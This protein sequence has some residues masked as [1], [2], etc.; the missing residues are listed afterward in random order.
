MKRAVV[1]GGGVL[2]TLHAYVAL[3]RGFEVVQLE[4]EADARG[5]SIRNFGLVWVSGRRGGEELDL[6]LRARTLWELLGE[7]VDG[8]GFR[9]NGSLTI[10]QKESELAVL[11][12]VLARR[13]AR[14]R[15]LAL[16][17]ADEVREVNPAIRGSVLGALHCRFDAA[18]EPR[19][20][21]R[22]IRAAMQRN[23]RYRF[24]PGRHV[25]ELGSGA[26]RDHLGERHSGDVVVVCPGAAA[27]GLRG[28]S[29][30]R[31][32][33]ARVRLQ[34]LETEPFPIA[35][36]TSIADQDSLRY[37]P[38]FDVPARS[39]LPSP[40]PLVAERHVQLLV[41]QRF[42]G[43]LTIGD[44]HDYEEP[45]DVALD[46]EPYRH[47]LARAESILGAPLP[48]VRRR[49]AGVYCQLRDGGLF[50]C[51]QAAER[52]WVVTGAGGRGM[53]LA[54]AIAERVWDALGD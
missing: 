28:W 37:Y 32:S 52:T 24:L 38:V 39:G 43:S 6:A 17:D 5:A 15:G 46:E 42:D 26:V 53:T 13:D 51:E 34:M 2:G 25:V 48:P 22:A 23:E 3:E 45:F 8:I 16:L 54:P 44:T 1:V 40:S 30:E 20:V 4:R 29:M 14:A 7:E 21:P 31:A 36:S 27:T 18:V 50:H 47:L 11:V 41:Q 9:G 19:R 10:V 12:Q 33:L 49:W 35:L